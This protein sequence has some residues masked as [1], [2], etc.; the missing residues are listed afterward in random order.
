MHLTCHMLHSTRHLCMCVFVIEGAWT[1]EYLDQGC[2][3]RG[4]RRRGGRGTRRKRSLSWLPLDDYAR[5]DI[6][7]LC[8]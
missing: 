1:G 2:N 7:S 6:V 8:G 3:Y 4:I 5:T